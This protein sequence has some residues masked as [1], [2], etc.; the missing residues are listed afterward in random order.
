MISSLTFVRFGLKEEKEKKKQIFVFFLMQLDEVLLLFCSSMHKFSSTRT[1]LIQEEE[2]K[3]TSP[4][5]V[6]KKKHVRDDA[7]VHLSLSLSM[8]K[9]KQNGT[10][11]FYV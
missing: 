7:N 8:Y 1:T 4:K 9:S 11:N 3:E 5:N 6:Y 10:E 2:E